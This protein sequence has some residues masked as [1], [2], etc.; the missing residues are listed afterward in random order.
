[1]QSGTVLFLCRTI[2]TVPKA[3]SMLLAQSCRM[4]KKRQNEEYGG[5]GA[6]SPR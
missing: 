3:Q 2:R 5:G 6:H 4:G 1:M